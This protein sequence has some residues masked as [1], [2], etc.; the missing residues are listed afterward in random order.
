MNRDNMLPDSEIQL[1]NLIWRHEPIKAIEL[2]AIAWGELGWKAPTTYTLLKRLCDKEVIRRGEP[3]FVVTS[4]MSREQIAQL[5]ANKIVNKLYDG[6]RKLFLASYIH[7]ES[8]SQ[9]DVAELRRM[10]DEY[11]GDLPQKSDSEKGV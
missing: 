1:M 9:E 8:L 10:L 7:K 3:D 2:S 5:H 11:E 6:S 4:L